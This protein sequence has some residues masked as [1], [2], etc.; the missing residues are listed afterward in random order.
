LP[1]AAERAVFEQL[2]G[3]L[4][5]LAQREGALA[6]SVPMAYVECERA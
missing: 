5:A 1:Q 3:N 2:E 6:L 4:N